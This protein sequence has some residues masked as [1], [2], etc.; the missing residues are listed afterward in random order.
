MNIYRNMVYMMVLYQ[1][2]I[3]PDR[4][5]S[6]KA[7]ENI[8]LSSWYEING[9]QDIDEYMD[10]DDDTYISR[11]IS[12]PQYQ[13][14]KTKIFNDIN[15]ELLYRLIILKDPDLPNNF[16][17]S[18][19][20]I[21]LYY[22]TYISKKR[23]MEV[24][25]DVST[26]EDVKYINTKRLIRDY[27]FIYCDSPIGIKNMLN[28]LGFGDYIFANSFDKFELLPHEIDYYS[29]RL[30]REEIENIFPTMGGKRRDT[31][32]NNLLSI[33]SKTGI[34]NIFI[35][36]IISSGHAREEF[37]Y[38][39]CVDVL[40]KPYS[41]YGMDR[42]HEQLKNHHIY[43]FYHE[44]VVD[45][46]DYITEINLLKALTIRQLDRDES[47][48]FKKVFPDMNY[49]NVKNALN[50]IDN[51]DTDLLMYMFNKSTDNNIKILLLNTMA[52]KGM[53]DIIYEQ[54]DYID[55][56][57]EKHEYQY[58]NNFDTIWEILYEGQPSDIMERC[59]IADKLYDVYVSYYQY[60]LDTI[61]LNNLV[62]IPI[63]YM[64]Y[65][66]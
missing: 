16:I 59:I 13:P 19:N 17:N 46:G 48:I 18:N 50:N 32:I 26:F 55:N 53:T 51:V 61:Y 24:E 38:K 65:H 43:R 42:P 63:Y 14:Y 44:H 66:R 29:R 8:R 60:V 11:I 49:D 40:K 12:F 7:L 37:A 6:L 45:T 22:A 54:Q 41:Y 28:M 5:L 15:T 23:D 20:T 34:R 33:C 62:H 10:Q 27:I 31:F 58:V 21:R 36:N 4:Q 47:K 25:R 2:N 35:E 56:I 57:M 3:Y 52:K 30:S 64:I 9:R 39:Y 1:K